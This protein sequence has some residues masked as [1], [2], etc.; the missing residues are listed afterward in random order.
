LL[1]AFSLF[2]VT[3]VASQPN[4]CVASEV[5]Y[6]AS[7]VERPAR[8]LHTNAADGRLIEVQVYRPASA[9]VDTSRALIPGVRWRAAPRVALAATDN[10]VGFLVDSTGAVVSCSIRLRLPVADSTNVIA[11]VSGLRFA[12]A[13]VAGKNVP[14]LF[15]ARLRR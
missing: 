11:L 4:R 2:A 3:W 12:P 10:L 5:P 9:G 6:L 14:Q 13:R 7:T 15:V 8:L 1:F